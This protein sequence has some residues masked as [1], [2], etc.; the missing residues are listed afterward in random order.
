[1]SSVCFKPE[2]AD[3]ASSDASVRRHLG[4]AGSHTQNTGAVVRAALCASKFCCSAPSLRDP[5][6]RRHGGSRGTH[7]NLARS[8][9]LHTAVT[10]SEWGG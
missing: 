7:K 8:G 9:W 2:T 3:T 5:G 6:R 1:V 4:R 10:G